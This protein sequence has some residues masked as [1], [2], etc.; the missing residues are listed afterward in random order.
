MLTACSPAEL[1]TVVEAMGSAAFVIDAQP[2][3]RFRYAASNRRHDRMI[4]NTG[5]ADGIVPEI[6]RLTPL[7][8]RLEAQCR[9]CVTTRGTVEYEAELDTP[10]G[11]AWWHTVLVPLFDDRGRCVRI[12]GTA[13]ETTA[14][15]R[16]DQ[17]MKLAERRLSALIDTA[18]VGILL[19]DIDF[20]IVLA[21]AYAED[22]FGVRHG[23]LHGRSYADLVVPDDMADA[24]RRLDSGFAGHRAPYQAQRRYRRAD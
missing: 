13:H 2:D 9:R 11:P 23:S 1:R 3:G 17:R 21:N 7:P 8:K 14:V 5:F 20:T 19:G 18:A 24:A 12:M 10:A 15:K 4:G 22:L 6:G 16:T